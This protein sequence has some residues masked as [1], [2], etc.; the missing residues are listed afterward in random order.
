MEEEG[1][2]SER[3]VIVEEETNGTDIDGIANLGYLPTIIFIIFWDVLL[4]NQIFLSP[5]VKG[6]AKL[7]HELPK[8][9]R[10]KNL[11]NK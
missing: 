4:L 3:V 9:L 1:N 10:L 5:P 8:G 11:G 2:P 7:H 6:S